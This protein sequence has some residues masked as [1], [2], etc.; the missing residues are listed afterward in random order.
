MGRSMLVV[1]ALA[2]L[3]VVSAGCK[4]QSAAKSPEKSDSAHVVVMHK[5]VVM[6]EERGPAHHAE[7]KPSGH[8]D[9]TACYRSEADRNMGRMR[10]D[11]PRGGSCEECGG[12]SGGSDCPCGR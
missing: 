9:C 2:A 4:T 7:A 11:L 5:E 8:A 3:L 10:D 12:T 6:H 1:A